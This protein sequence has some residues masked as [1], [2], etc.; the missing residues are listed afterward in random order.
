MVDG[1]GVQGGGEGSADGD[2][3]CCA[4]PEH[5]AHGH[6]PGTPHQHLAIYGIQYNLHSKLGPLSNC[7]SARLCT[8]A[9][10]LCACTCSACTE[11]TPSS[12]VCPNTR[13]FRHHAPA[14]RRR[15]AVDAH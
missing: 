14:V 8:L 2:K 4:R 1:K 7:I 3:T 12:L 15:G 10:V 11:S 6:D 9:G 5:K 13:T